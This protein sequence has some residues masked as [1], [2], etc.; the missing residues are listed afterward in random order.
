MSDVFV[1]AFYCNV[2]NRDDKAF[3]RMD[4]VTVNA[5]L[6]LRQ[7]TRARPARGSYLCLSL[8]APEPEETNYV[9]I[10]LDSNSLLTKKYFLFYVQGQSIV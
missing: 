9:E 8:D 7:S 10:K 1:P 2:V 5:Y 3:W 4:K 6:C